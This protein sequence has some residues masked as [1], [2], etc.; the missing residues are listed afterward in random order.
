LFF[1]PR[2][3]GRGKLLQIGETIAYENGRAR[4]KQRTELK[5]NVKMIEDK[6]I[7]DKM[8]RNFSIILSIGFELCHGL[9]RSMS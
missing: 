1:H 3:S 9:V 5:F 4:R 2:H 7:E 6:I 8:I